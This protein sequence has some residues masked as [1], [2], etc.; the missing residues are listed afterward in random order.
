VWVDW[1]ERHPVVTA[2]VGVVVAA[3]VCGVLFGL[4]EPDIP[5]WA[6]VAI[7][8]AAGVI[9]GVAV[10]LQWSHNPLPAVDAA[11]RAR[12]RRAVRTGGPVDRADAP[13][14][15]AFADT[16]LGIPFQPTVGIVLF[17]AMALFGVFQLVP[18]IEHGDVRHAVGS[19][20]VV[21]AFV[22]MTFVT[23]LTHRRRRRVEAARRR[24]LEVLGQERR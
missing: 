24:A 14:V 18:A 20:V 11:T 8:V 6:L 15:V 7:V 2:A 12:V 9:V 4:V 21:L 1:M 17:A 22:L 13:H 10:R 3:G 16:L 23:S 5:T 19:G